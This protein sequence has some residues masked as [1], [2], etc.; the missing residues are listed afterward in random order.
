MCKTVS[1]SVVIL[2][3]K[4][5]SERNGCVALAGK[6]VY[7]AW[8]LKARGDWVRAVLALGA[9]SFVVIIEEADSDGLSALA[10]C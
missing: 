2:K 7:A 3:V 6:A 4:F 5:C 1:F 8:G 10:S 9:F